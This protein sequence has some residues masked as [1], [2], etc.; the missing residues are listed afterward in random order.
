MTMLVSPSVCLIWLFSSLRAHRFFIPKTDI[1]TEPLSK[2]FP[3]R[4]EPCVV[5]TENI[6]VTI[7]LWCDDFF[8]GVT[9]LWTHMP[10]C[11]LVGLLDAWLVRRLVCQKLHLHAPIGAVVFPVYCFSRIVKEGIFP[12]TR[13]PLFS[14]QRTLV[15]WPGNPC[16]VTR[17]PLFSDQ[18]TLVQWPGN[19]CSVTREPL[20]SDQGTLAQ[21]PGN[22]CSVTREPREVTRKLYIYQ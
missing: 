9:F 6:L 5:V 11:W 18:G 22:P 16:S 14:D 4:A 17:E 15:Q 19:P 12:L 2:S 1:S 20:F 8:G 10:V 7:K 3:V 13:E 21:W